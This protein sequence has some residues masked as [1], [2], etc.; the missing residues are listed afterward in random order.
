MN[1]ETPI[2]VMNYKIIWER[3][4]CHWEGDYKGRAMCEEGQKR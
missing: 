4:H 3:K 1:S 2:V